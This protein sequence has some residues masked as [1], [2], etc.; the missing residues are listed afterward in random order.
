MT[1]FSYTWKPEHS[2]MVEKIPSNKSHL[3]DTIWPQIQLYIVGK[4]KILA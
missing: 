2:S 1:I 4:C 3:L